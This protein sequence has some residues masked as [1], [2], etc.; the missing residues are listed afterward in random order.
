[1]ESLFA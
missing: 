1:Q